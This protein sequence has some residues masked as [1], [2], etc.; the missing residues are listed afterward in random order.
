MIGVL[1]AQVWHAVNKT[2]RPSS[3]SQSVDGVE[4]RYHRKT[5]QISVNIDGQTYHRSTEMGPRQYDLVQKTTLKLS[6]WLDS[7]GYPALSSAAR[8]KEETQ[9]AAAPNPAK[10]RPDVPRL[11]LKPAD[12]MRNALRAEIPY[13]KLPNQ[14]IVAQIDDVLQ[15]KLRAAGRM[16]DAVRLMEWPNKGMVVMVG[17]EQYDSIDDVPD[18]TI[19]AIIRAAVQEWEQAG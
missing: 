2:E 4:I 13:S 7:A 6:A 3:E 14:S 12:V 5:N 8:P 18:E 10:N 9:P 1:I 16:D 15:E 17:L 19:R 11:S